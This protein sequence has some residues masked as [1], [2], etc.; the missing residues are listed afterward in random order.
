MRSIKNKKGILGIDVVKSFMI[1]ILALAII[2]I[3]IVII[4]NALDISS[5]TPASSGSASNETLLS[6]NETGSFFANSI[7]NSVVCSVFEVRN[8]TTP[9]TIASGNYTVNNCLISYS[10]P[11]DSSFNNSLWNVSYTYTY[12]DFEGVDE[13]IANTSQGVTDFFSNAPTFFVLLG[14]VVII[15]II[16]IVVISVNNFGT[17]GGKS[18]EGI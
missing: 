10:A 9:I 16:S 2:A 6:V 1:G 13:V 14:V 8:A 12:D 4:M 17:T 11:E 5:L 3:A 18:Y 15:L 7:R